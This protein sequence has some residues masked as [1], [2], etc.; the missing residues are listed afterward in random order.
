M[1]ST[2]FVTINCAH[3]DSLSL[4]HLSALL[5]Y[6]SRARDLM[7]DPRINLWVRFGMAMMVGNQIAH[8]VTGKDPADRWFVF[9]R[10]GFGRFVGRSILSHYC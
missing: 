10:E 9:S 1:K 8:L 7:E 4:A 5:A 6:T 3:C 2:P